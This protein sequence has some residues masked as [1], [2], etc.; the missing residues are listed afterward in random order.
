MSPG[1][2][3][4]SKDPWEYRPV[5]HKTAQ[6]GKGRVIFIGPKAQDAL[7]PY[8]IRPDDQHCFR[9]VDSETKRRR[10]L[11]DARKTPLSCGNKPGS[12]RRRRPAHQPGEAYQKDALNRAVRRAVDKLNEERKCN[13]LEPIPRWTPYQ[14]RHAWG[15]RVRKDFGLEHAQ[16]VLGHSQ[17]KVTEIYAARD[18]EKAREAIRRIG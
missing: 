4:T 10:A 5:S 7:R 2:L 8:L 9:P 16:C 12:N 13:G 3:D 6:L 1:R 15:T 18:Q 14:L 11:N 17:A